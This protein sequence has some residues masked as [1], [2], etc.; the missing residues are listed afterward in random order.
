MVGAAAGYIGTNPGHRVDF[1]IM[2]NDPR[3]LE[4]RGLGQHQE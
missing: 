2:E 1:E 3:V 4:I